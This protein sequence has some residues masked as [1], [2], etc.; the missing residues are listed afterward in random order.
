LR[1]IRWIAAALFLG[2]LVALSIL[3]E[4]FKGLTSTHGLMHDA[5]HITAFLAAF[6]ISAG[7]SRTSNRA[8]LWAFALLCFGALLEVL[9]TMV[10]GNLL[11]YG[12]ILDD[13]IGVIAGL[14]LVSAVR[15]RRS[16]IIE[17]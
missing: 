14:W 13:A 4:P 11:E 15:P 3:P 5:V 10:Y 7:Q 6:L 1:L 16:P 17:K 2:A 8:L 12:D 9:Q